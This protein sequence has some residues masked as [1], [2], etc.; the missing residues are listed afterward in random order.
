MILRL[1]QKLNKKIKAGKLTEM[2]L[3]ENPYADWSCHLFTADHTQYIIMSNTASLYSCVM[4]GKGITDDSQFIERALCAIRE[5]MED[6]GQQFA[7]RKFIAPASGTVSFAKALNRS[8]TGSMNDHVQ[9]TKFYLADHM[10][11]HEVG[12]RINETPLSALTNADGRKYAKPREVFKRLMG[13]Q[14]SPSAS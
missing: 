11:P 13:D 3:D 6:D 14:S 4:Y 5:F 12:F 9:A 2:Q 8:V 1:S 10:S 7:Y